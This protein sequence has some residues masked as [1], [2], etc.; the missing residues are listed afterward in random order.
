MQKHKELRGAHLELLAQAAAAAATTACSP[1]EA[2]FPIHRFCLQTV[3]YRIHADSNIEKK[4]KLLTKI[5]WEDQNLISLSI[6]EG[7]W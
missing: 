6:I 3:V 2:A 4:K 1:K 7:P 5:T